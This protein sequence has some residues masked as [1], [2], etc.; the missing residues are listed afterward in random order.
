MLLK[1]KR[2]LYGITLA[3]KHLYITNRAKRIYN[4]YK[5]STTNDSMG[6]KK[7]RKSYQMNMLIGTKGKELLLEQK[8][9][10]K[11]GLSGACESP[12]THR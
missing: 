8:L 7:N 5:L 9:C 1:I 3:L 11:S 4:Q 10:L 12:E 2:L 6:S